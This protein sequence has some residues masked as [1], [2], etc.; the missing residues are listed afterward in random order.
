MLFP[1]LRDVTKRHSRTY[2][3]KQVCLCDT[4]DFHMWH[5]K[6]AHSDGVLSY[7]LASNGR[8]K[9]LWISRGKEAYLA[10][11]VKNLIAIDQ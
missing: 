5:R 8:F 10:M 9:E 3:H 1:T 2:G 4:A 7:F 6:T 11:R